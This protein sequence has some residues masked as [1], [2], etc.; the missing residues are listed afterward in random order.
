MQEQETDVGTQH[1]LSCRIRN[2][3]EVLLIQGETNFIETVPYWFIQIS[4]LVFFIKFLRSLPRVCHILLPYINRNPSEI[5]GINFTVENIPC[6]RF[7]LTVFI[8]YKLF[9]FISFN[10]PLSGHGRRLHLFSQIQFQT[11]AECIY[12]Q[13]CTRCL[14]KE[15][16]FVLKEIRDLSLEIVRC[17]RSYGFRKRQVKY[18]R[19]QET[20]SFVNIFFE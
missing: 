7:L 3:S 18:N 19:D 2:K 15:T 16:L 9:I 4:F 8:I 11:S 14:Y 10:L 6:I 5:K 12:S 13:T 20:D 17:E 1:Q